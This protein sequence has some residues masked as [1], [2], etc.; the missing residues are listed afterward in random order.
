MCREAA[1]AEPWEGVGEAV[2]AKTHKAQ[3]CGFWWNEM[4][5]IAVKP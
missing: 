4:L 5:T 3:E 1:M 2:M